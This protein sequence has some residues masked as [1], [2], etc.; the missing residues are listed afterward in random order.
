MAERKESPGV[1]P[2]ARENSSEPEPNPNSARR[3]L[4]PAK[5]REAFRR[6]DVARALVRLRMCPPPCERRDLL[7]AL[8]D[9][10][11]DG[12]NAA[13]RMLRSKISRG[14]GDPEDGR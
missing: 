13:E 6:A 3:R 12:I 5:S 1:P 11:I 10:G 2:R 8:R 7:E 9:A 4:D 14:F